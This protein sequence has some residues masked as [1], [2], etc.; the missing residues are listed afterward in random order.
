MGPAYRIDDEQAAVIGTLADPEAKVLR[1]QFS[2]AHIERLDQSRRVAP[3]EKTSPI[4]AMGA[5]MA[6]SR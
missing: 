6:V 2:T 3:A 1:R 5:N 4:R